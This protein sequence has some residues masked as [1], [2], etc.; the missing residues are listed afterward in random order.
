MFYQIHTTSKSFQPCQCLLILCSCPL[1]QGATPYIDPPFTYIIERYV[2]GIHF[3]Q[4]HA[5]YYSQ[6]KISHFKRKH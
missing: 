3:H 6:R 2:Y 5:F 4:D 1:N